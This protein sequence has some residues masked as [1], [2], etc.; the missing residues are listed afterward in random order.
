MIQ[1]QCFQSRCLSK[2]E[3]SILVFCLRITRITCWS[4]QQDNLK[5][6][7]ASNSGKQIWRD[8]RVYKSKFCTQCVVNRSMTDDIYGILVTSKKL[9]KTLA[10][11]W[12]YFGSLANMI[13]LQTPSFGWSF[14]DGR[15]LASKPAHHKR[16]YFSDQWYK[17][18]Y[19]K[20]YIMYFL[21]PV[22]IYNIDLI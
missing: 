3:S 19:R 6:N 13:C 2:K 1:Y 22:I 16:S 11:F 15:Q 21:L 20:I 17:L 10:A 14:Q 4:S 18:I 8:V 9:T 12:T 5:E 7:S